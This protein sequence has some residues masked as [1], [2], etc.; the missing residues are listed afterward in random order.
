[1]ARTVAEIQRLFLS[2]PRY[3]VVGASKDQSKYGTKVLQWYLARNLSVTP[4]HPKE[5]KLEGVATVS[6]LAD[7]PAPTETSVSI[8]TNPKELNVPALWLQPGAEDDAVKD[9]IHANGLGDKVLYG[10]PCIL[11]E[12]D[13]IRKKSLL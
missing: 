3:A 4:V 10:G 2:S 11:V 13:G 6:D 1:M 8:I 5:S 7:I 12:G 9:Y